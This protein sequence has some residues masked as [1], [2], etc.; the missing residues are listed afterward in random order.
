[1]HYDY[2]CPWKNKDG[3]WTGKVI[4][5]PLDTIR[6]DGEKSKEV[7]TIS[8][9]TKNSETEVIEEMKRIIKD[10]KRKV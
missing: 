8:L 7:K 1:M 4:E 10:L 9:V 2:M 5:V 6:R 3:S